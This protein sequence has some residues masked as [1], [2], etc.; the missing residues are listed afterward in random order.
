MKLRTVPAI[1]LPIVAIASA[2]LGSQLVDAQD[3]SEPTLELLHVGINVTDIEAAADYFKEVIGMTETMRRNYEN[4]EIELLFLQHGD[5]LTVEL[6]PV[7][8]T[9]A[10]GL[11]HFGVRVEDIAAATALYRSRGA[12]I[13]EIWTTPIGARLADITTPGGARMELIQQP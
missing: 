3:R 7:T 2:I 4:G 9:R 10:V 8:P 13:S 1:W 5:S 12:E 6:N 11:G